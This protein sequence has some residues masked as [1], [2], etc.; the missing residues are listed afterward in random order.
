MAPPR[1]TLALALPTLAL[2][3]IRIS[4][5][6][7]SITAGVCSSG[8]GDYP[9]QLQALVG[10]AYVVSNYGNSGKT[11]LHAGLCGPPAGG[12]CAYIHTPTWPAALASTPDIVT[13]MLGTNDAKNFNWYPN[14]TGSTGNYTADTLAM[15]S[16][17]AALPSKP[18]IWLMIPPPLCASLGC[19]GREV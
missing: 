14:V 18:A 7:D 9:S 12:D 16:A 17:L 11:Q 13:I 10:P 5:I 2:A 3:A 8:G 4:M 1:Y 6:G 15:I 19:G